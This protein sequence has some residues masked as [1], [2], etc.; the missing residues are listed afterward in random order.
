MNLSAGNTWSLKT[1]KDINKM[2]M[3][4]FACKLCALG[5][6]NPFKSIEELANYRVVA[7]VETDATTTSFGEK[8]ELK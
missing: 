6:I 2:E 1:Q 5:N 3:N 4:V 8:S 7:P